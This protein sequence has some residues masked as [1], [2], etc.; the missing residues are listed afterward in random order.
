MWRYNPRVHPAQIA[1]VLEIALTMLSL[2]QKMM[3]AAFDL[4]LQLT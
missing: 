1:N 3:R 4:F 2:E